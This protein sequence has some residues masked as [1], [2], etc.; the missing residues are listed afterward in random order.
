[1]STG[2][3]VIRPAGG[4]GGGKGGRFWFVLLAV[5][6]AGAFFFPG[7]VFSGDPAAAIQQW[8]AGLIPVAENMLGW[9]AVA[10][11]VIVAGVNLFWHLL[12]HIHPGMRST[13]ETHIRHGY[14]T[15]GYLVGMKVLLPAGLVAVVV[16]GGALTQRLVVTVQHWKLQ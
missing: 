13:A 7:L 12:G 16:L 9:L 4:G 10:A 5:V 1:M 3:T 14:K 8:V 11:I 15:F 2:G 6:A